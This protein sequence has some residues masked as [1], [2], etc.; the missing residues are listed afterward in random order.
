[1]CQPSI[2]VYWSFSKTKRRLKCDQVHK[3]RNV[4][5]TI[6]KSYSC[7]V[8]SLNPNATTPPHSHKTFQ[9]T[10]T[11]WNLWNSHLPLFNFFF[12]ECFFFLLFSFVLFSFFFCFSVFSSFLHFAKVFYG[13]FLFWTSRTAYFVFFLLLFTT[14]FVALPPQSFFFLFLV[15]MLVHLFPLRFVGCAPFSNLI[16][17][18][19]NQPNTNHTLA[20]TAASSLIFSE[21]KSHPNAKTVVSMH[22]LWPDEKEKKMKRE[23]ESS[24]VVAC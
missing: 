13:H 7:A 16:R 2:H 19:T 1:M 24:N 9:P 4:L 23:R 21:T 15:S 18:A 17:T 12:S 8:I 20:F 22:S 10:G 11:S 5:L 14:C 6:R 3:H